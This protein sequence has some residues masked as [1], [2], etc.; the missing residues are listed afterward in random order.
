MRLPS[1]NRSPCWA[2]STPDLD[3]G[4]VDAVH[5]GREGLGLS[6][7]LGLCL[8]LGLALPCSAAGQPGLVH[9]ILPPGH[10]WKHQHPSTQPGFQT[11]HV[12]ESALHPSLRTRLR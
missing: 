6:V 10:P 2:D 8:D 1:P 3:L 5:P 11:T 4:Q 12:P 7:G 9:F